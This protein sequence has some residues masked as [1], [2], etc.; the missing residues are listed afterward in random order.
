[1]DRSVL[2]VLAVMIMVAFGATADAADWETDF[3]KAAT[4]ASKSGMCMLLDFSGSDWC[5]WCIKLEEEVFSKK[6]FKEYAKKNLICVLVDFPRQKKLSKKLK[7]QNAA[8]AKKYAIRGYPT[9]IIL[10]QDRGSGGQNRLSG[11]R[12]EELRRTLEG[13]DHRI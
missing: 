12:R 3:A 7:D 10:S 1:M 9:V 2:T 5:G 8:L 13:D 6:E 11:R 4:N